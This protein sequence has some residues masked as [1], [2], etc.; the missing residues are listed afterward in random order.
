M[1]AKD[2]K[3]NTRDRIIASAR[4]LFA[5]RGYQQTTVVD[6]SKQA[7]LSEA[8]LYEY[9]QGKE[10][11]LLTIPDMWVSELIRDLEDHLFGIRG[12]CNKLRKFLW[13][14][15]RRLEESPLD[16]KIVYLFLKTNANFLNTEVYSNV[17]ILYGFLLKIFEEGRESGELRP[18]LDPYLAREVFVGTMEHV[19]TLWLLK[20]QSFSLFEK[21]ESLFDLM[22]Y[23]FK[24]MDAEEGATMET[25][26]QTD[27]V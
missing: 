1:A 27:S 19:V 14:Y 15:L 16:A 12:A 3:G 13:W 11:L 20:G 26:Q 2:T 8:A 22:L 7:G 9:F 25:T 6:I 10:D 5:E 18:D 24:G 4:Q 23:G 17:K 21:L